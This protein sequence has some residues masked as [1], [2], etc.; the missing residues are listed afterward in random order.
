MNSGKKKIKDA[1]PMS[2]QEIQDMLFVGVTNNMNRI[3][4]Y[5]INNRYQRKVLPVL[6]GK[7][8]PGP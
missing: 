3:K 7:I 4:D 5:N 2:K 1:P 6:L 8:G